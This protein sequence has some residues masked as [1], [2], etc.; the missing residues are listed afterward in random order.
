[1]TKHQE[2][3]L[4]QLGSILSRRRRL[5]LV[6]AG[7]C[8]A[9]AVIVNLVT[10][11]IYR[12]TVC[13]EVRK[14][15][16]RSP[17]TGEAIASDQWQSDNIAVFTAAELVTNR[18]LLGE[19][20][21]KLD[22]RGL[23]ADMPGRRNKPAPGAGAATAAA[24]PGPSGD[25]LNREI[26]WLNTITT[27]KPVRDTRLFNIEVEHWNPATA[28][29][30][31]DILAGT[32]VT[33]KARWLANADSSRAGEMSQQMEDTR[34]RMKNLEAGLNGTSSKAPVILSE[35]L[36]QLSDAISGL[37]ESYVK[38]QT[39]RM[40]VDARLARV[41]AVLRDSLRDAGGLPVQSE[42]LDALWSNL[43]S[44]QTDLARAREVYRDGHPKVM[45]LV[46]DIRNIQRSIRAE[47][48][49][50]VATLEQEHV[51]LRERERNLQATIAAR[52]AKLHQV[53]NFLAQQTNTQSEL[54]SSR[55]IYNVLSTRAQ[56]DQVSGAVRY[57]LVQV[58][59]SAT[60]GSKPVRPR[61][62]LNM[63]LG[64]VVGLMAG[65]GLALMQEY[66]REVIRTPIDATEQL[67]LPVLGMIPKRS[68][69]RSGS[70]A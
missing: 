29:S 42:A 24:D 16:N 35:Q 65:T 49:K 7:A 39:D 9:L 20:A 62:L 15:P 66:L 8:L 2:I 69:E 12:A 28:T 38:I 5:I 50:T 27:V 55:Q 68:Q 43:L 34:E 48:A 14:E 67:Q 10:R 36:K 33:A 63:V 45:M 41:R 53:S 59:G 51:V 19:V 56:E 57:P 52:E 22:R 23:L 47:L 13:V 37:N 18:T 54:Q 30:I 4:K 60:V 3:D 21:Q 17:L 1:M 46:S 31:A 70:P 32:F 11:P 26:D 58:V 25:E 61:R 40:A 64:V 6:A 44:R